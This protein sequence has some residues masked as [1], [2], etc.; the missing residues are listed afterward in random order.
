MSTLKCLVLHLNTNIWYKTTVLFKKVTLLSKPVLYAY[1]T[2]LLFGGS[3]ST[4]SHRIV[5]IATHFF[6]KRQPYLEL[7]NY[8]ITTT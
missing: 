6:V 3:I 7:S 8:C 5:G 2:T 1:N 4:Q